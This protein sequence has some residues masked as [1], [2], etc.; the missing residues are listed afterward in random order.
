[1]LQ[2]EDIFVKHLDAYPPRMRGQIS[3]LPL[4]DLPRAS[5]QGHLLFMFTFIVMLASISFLGQMSEM[6]CSTPPTI[7]QQS[8]CREKSRD[9]VRET[10]TKVTEIETHW[11]GAA[12]ARVHML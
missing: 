9:G 12:S 5:G 7:P 11:S 4:R 1:M 10:N 3:L 2:V 8:N 6:N